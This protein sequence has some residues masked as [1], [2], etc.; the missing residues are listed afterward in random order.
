MTCMQQRLL[1]FLCTQRTVN[2]HEHVFV[3][4][5]ML[6][7]FA[8]QTR[9]SSC[10]RNLCLCFP[11]D[12]C[13]QRECT[14]Q[15]SLLL[16]CATSPCHLQVI[17]EAVRAEFVDSQLPRIVESSGLVSNITG[18]VPVLVCITTLFMHTL[19]DCAQ[20]FQLATNWAFML[21]AAH[22]HTYC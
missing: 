13:L 16:G 2:V 5:R 3:W 12:S 17:A 9:E 1:S 18:W 10:M 19:T 4:V 21:Y 20:I 15:V 7:L 8:T 22:D 14:A 11:L 6:T